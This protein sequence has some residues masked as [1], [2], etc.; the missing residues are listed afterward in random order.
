MRR[1]Y[2]IGL[3]PNHDVQPFLVTI[4][5]LLNK[6]QN[7]FR[8]CTYSPPKPLR[9]MEVRKSADVDTSLEECHA[10]KTALNLASEDLLIQFIGTPLESRLRG[11]ANL[12]LA[13]SDLSE[14]PPRVAV[15]STS[16]IHRHILPSDPTYLTQRN[17]FYHLMVCCIA[18]AFFELLAHDDRGCVMDFNS[19]TPNIRRKIDSG[20]TFCDACTLV[21][22]KHSL[23]DALFKICSALKA[24]VDIGR[25]AELSERNRRPRVFLCY[26]G[27]DRVSVEK[28]YDRLLADGFLPWMDKK[29]LLPGQA[30]ELEI[31]HAI[32]SADY[33][34][35]CISSHFQRR[36]YGLREIKLALDV[37]DTIP[38]GTIF[39]IPARL[40]HCTIEDRLAHRQW[41]D[42]FESD[43]YEKLIKALRTT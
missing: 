42:L 19:Y 11:L 12:F 40:E 15:I 28:L 30:W 13:G 26:A 41:V 38:E 10:L 43:G 23:C 7:D 29:D 16:F 33:F 22:E 5:D 1:L 27:P 21:V 25:P 14:R 6:V 4:A 35:A 36:T 31:R 32:N 9:S 2:Q 8:F 3:I 34:V 24:G 37:L 39:L 18:S 20:Y 17:A